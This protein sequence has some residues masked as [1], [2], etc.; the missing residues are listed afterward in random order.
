MFVIYYLLFKAACDGC[1]EAVRVLV[2]AGANVNLADKDGWTPLYPSFSAKLM[3]A[4][5]STS[6]LVAFT[7]PLLAAPYKGASR[8]LST[9]LMSAPFSTSNLIA[10]SRLLQAAPYK[11]I[12]PSLSAKPTSAPAS[13][14]TL[15]A[16][17]LPSKRLCTQYLVNVRIHCASSTRSSHDNNNVFAFSR[18]LFKGALSF[19]SVKLT[20][21]LALKKKVPT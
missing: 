15:I 4:P 12:H 19:L 18:P 7:H 5:A 21:A 2:E 8:Y 9:K 17:F 20:S 16:S 10:Y 6:T 13:T 11:G 3:F 1:E 14:S